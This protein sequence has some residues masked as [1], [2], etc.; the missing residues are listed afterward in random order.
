MFLLRLRLHVLWASLGR[1][2]SPLLGRP[3]HRCRQP[4]SQGC[5]LQS[6]TE[7]ATM[8]LGRGSLPSSPPLPPPLPPAGCT[9]GGSSLVAV[10]CGRPPSMHSSKMW[11]GSGWAVP[12]GILPRG[13]LRGPSSLQPSFSSPAPGVLSR[14]RWPSTW[15]GTRWQYTADRYE[16]VLVM[17]VQQCDN[18]S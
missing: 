13:G 8:S 18:A 12:E 15:V 7:R 5:M 11:Q 6:S 9:A 17:L 1:P 2:F 16:V 14:R 10:A 4:G 3:G